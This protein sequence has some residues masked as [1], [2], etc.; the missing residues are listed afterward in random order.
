MAEDTEVVAKPKVTRIERF[1]SLQAGHYWEALQ[2]IPS[3]NIK[4]GDVLLIE[5]LRWVDDECHT[6]VL[7]AHP[8][9]Y[10]R[11]WY[12]TVTDEYGTRQRYKGQLSEHRFLTNDFLAKFQ[13]APKAD[14]VRKAELAQIQGRIKTLQDELLE[15]QTSRERFVAIAAAEMAADKAKKGED[16]TPVTTADQ[17]IVPTTLT[18]E[19]SVASA[20]EAGITREKIDNFR[21]MVLAEAKVAEVQ[22]KWIKGKVDQISSSVQEMTPYYQ[23]QAAAALAQTEDVR[24]YVKSLTDGIESLELYVGTNVDV[25]EVR[26]G[27]SAP[28]TSPLT[29]LQRKLY[30][31]EELSVW[32][33]VGAEFDFRSQDRFDEALR[34]S[35][36]LVN[37]IFASDRCIVAMAVSRRPRDYGDPWVTKAFNENNRA[38]FLMIRD[39]ENIYRVH[40]PVESHL[41]T[42]RLF[43]AT[44]ESLNKFHGIDGSTITMQDVRYTDKLAS[45]EAMALH[46]KRFLILLCG[47]DHRLNLFGTFYPGPKSMQFVSAEFQQEYLRF[48]HDDDGE[49]MLPGQAKPSFA[50]WIDQMNE[51]VRDGARLF[52]SWYDMTSYEAAPGAYTRGQGKPSRNVDFISDYGV[53]VVYTRNKRLYVDA[54][55]K[56]Y[57]YTQR[58]DRFFNVRTRVVTDGSLY[59]EA[60]LPFLCLDN[61]DPEALDWYI[62]D[63][64]SREDFLSYVESFKRALA[65][66]RE[67]RQEEEETRIA[68]RNALLEANIASSDDVL[69]IVQKTVVTWRATKSGRKLP[70]WTEASTPDRKSILDLAYLLAGDAKRRATEIEAFANSQGYQPLRLSAAGSS[71]LLLY[72]APKPEERD[73]RMFPHVWTHKWVLEPKKS[74]DYVI[75][76]SEWVILPKLSA[77]ETVIAEWPT[78][79]EWL[80][81]PQPFTSYEQKQEMFNVISQFESVT[82]KMMQATP[83]Y[84]DELLSHYRTLRRKISTRGN[85]SEPDFMLPFGIS[86]RKR[87]DSSDHLTF[88]ALGTTGPYVL[89]YRLS[90]DSQFK[91]TV[92]RTYIDFYAQKKSAEERF[93]KGANGRFPLLLMHAGPKF[94]YEHGGMTAALEAHTSVTWDAGYKD[95][96]DYFRLWLEELQ[97]GNKRHHTNRTVWLPEAVKQP[98]YFSGLLRSLRLDDIEPRES[99]KEKEKAEDE[100]D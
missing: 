17:S 96:D 19:M 23:E 28:I 75:K 72:V 81:E 62:H 100:N 36:G 89:M 34:T 49:G 68:I 3:E 8:S 10:G 57:S 29:I 24:S 86:H 60:G 61:I 80:L 70:K 58:K 40:S 18:S 97:L 54:P 53:A 32:A 47:L 43:P 41:G 45:F 16:Y 25:I 78:A 2:D 46:Y 5:S 93:D 26:K 73:D 20:I 39:G 82:G 6:V 87:S 71:R 91:A 83:G 21:S 13:Y 84:M 50:T 56:Q 66:V 31:D 22:A 51:Y 52:C 44:D 1:Q 15:G 99:K 59:N 9:H 27:E 14:E 94:D 95:L 38:A 65:F 12:E 42:A 37:Q 79:K 33:D 4:K 98:G 48:I 63:R 88:L 64:N 11:S 90:T 55:V 77:S 7:R 67:E 92:R 35:E 69:E 74:G 30:M 85:V 76:S